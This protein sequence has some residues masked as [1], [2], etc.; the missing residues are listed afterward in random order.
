MRSCSFSVA[1]HAASAV[2]RLAASPISYAP[3]LNALPPTYHSALLD[4]R[5]SD[6]SLFEHEVTHAAGLEPD[7]RVKADRAICMLCRPPYGLCIG[8]QIHLQ[9]RA[10]AAGAFHQGGPVMAVSTDEV[11]DALTR[12]VGRVFDVLCPVDRR[13]AE[14]PAPY[15]DQKEPERPH[16]FR[17]SSAR[18]SGGSISP[19]PTPGANTGHGVPSSSYSNSISVR[20]IRVMA[21][22]R[23]GWFRN[24]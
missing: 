12:C 13:S 5:P 22:W 7:R 16:R 23:F 15:P 18:F 21:K 4:L 17:L 24:L 3:A 2:F 19:A 14:K 11:Y 1:S 20:L 9:R 8:Q 6:A 10:A